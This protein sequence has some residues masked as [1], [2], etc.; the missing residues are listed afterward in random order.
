MF[1]VLGTGLFL[2]AGAGAFYYWWTHNHHE[3]RDDY[4]YTRDKIRDTGEDI[5][6]HVER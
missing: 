2:A 4:E 3:M 6:D 5:V 1:K